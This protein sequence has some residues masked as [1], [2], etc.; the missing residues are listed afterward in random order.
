MPAPESVKKEI[1]KL[2]GEINYHNEKYYRENAPVISD[3][4]YD[5]LMRRL[6]ELEREY[7]ELVTPTHPPSGWAR[8]RWKNS[9]NA[10]TSC[11]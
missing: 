2:R 10:P 5:K 6:Q 8:R 11:P 1:D 3:A 9:R 7:P 4:E